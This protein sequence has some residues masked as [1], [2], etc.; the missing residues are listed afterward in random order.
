MSPPNN[1]ASKKS[2]WWNQYHITVNYKTNQGKVI[3]NGIEINN[4]PLSGDKWD[5]MV[6]NSKFNK[7]SGFGKYKKG[8]ISFQDHKPGTV[9]YKR[10]Y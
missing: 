4:F 2:R 6:K 3:L 7:M 5:A 10:K 8:H 1:I 9:S